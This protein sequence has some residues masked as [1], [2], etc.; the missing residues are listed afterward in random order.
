MKYI[1]KLTP[2]SS[3]DIQGL[4]S[5][6]QDMAL[7]GLYLKKYRPLFC[8]F[9][10]A[11][12]KPTRCRVEPYHRHLDEELPQ[13]MLELYE[14]YG[15]ECVGEISREMLLFA[16]QD[17]SAPELHTDPQLQGELWRKLVR[18]VR[19]S[20]LT[21]IA[22]I[23]LILVLTV[24]LISGGP[25]QALLTTATPVL[26]LA[27][28]AFLAG[29]PHQYADLREVTRFTRQLEAGQALTHREAYPKKSYV[30]LVSI[31]G[32]AV[33]LALLILVQYILPFTGGLRPVEETEDF[34]PL[35]LE[36]LEGDRYRKHAVEMDGVDYANFSRKEQ[37]LLCTQWEVVQTS[38]WSPNGE[39]WTRLELHWYRLPAPLSFLS[40]P[41]AQELLQDAMELDDDIWWTSGEEVAWDV[42]YSPQE[43]LDLLAAARRKGG[44]FQT[45]VAAAGNQAV[46]VQYT[47]SGDLTEHWENIAA[48]VQ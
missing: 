34:T 14:S 47:G 13:S 2:V 35:S 26:L 31:L 6:L 22:L 28:L 42:T 36:T 37:Y 40:K 15:W 12:A 21:Q 30:P 45:A 17:E 8:T 41:L 20:F 4:E 9:Y 39:N 18:R 48:M 11:P 27:L 29:V 32:Y 7:Q 5:W 19:R 38:K 24:F 3:Y 44:S 16:T 23:V 10:S 1:R 43:G 25:V 46:L 33:L